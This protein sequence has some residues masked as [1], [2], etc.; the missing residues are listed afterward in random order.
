[1]ILCILPA[2]QDLST[3]EAVLL[4]RKFDKSGDRTLGVITK[5]DLRGADLV[6]HI[7]NCKI[8]VGK[9]FVMVRAYSM[10]S[11]MMHLQAVL[12]GSEHGTKPM[13]AC[14]VI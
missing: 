5:P 3:N 4:A 13:F 12:A 10:T 9:G 8:K 2:P 6:A 7:N 14:F 11:D 1:M